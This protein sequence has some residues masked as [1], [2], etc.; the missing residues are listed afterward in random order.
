MPSRGSFTWFSS[1]DA[2]ISRMR[3]ASRRARAWSATGTPRPFVRVSGPGTLRRLVGVPEQLPPN[4]QQ[5]HLGVFRNQPLASVE[6]LAHVRGVGGDGGDADLRPAMQVGVAH[7]G[8]GHR[9]P[10]AQLGHDRPY[11]GP[12]LLQR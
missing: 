8:R 7:F 6:Q 3:T 10:P 9:V 4:G 11:D 2:T 1:V 12:L 5:L